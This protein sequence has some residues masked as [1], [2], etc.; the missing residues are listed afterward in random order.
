[1]NVEIRLTER[2]AGCAEIGDGKLFR[3]WEALALKK[4]TSGFLGCKVYLFKGFFA[5]FPQ[6][7]FSGR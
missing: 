3:K 5:F 1:M 7:A 2:K 4:R 6:H